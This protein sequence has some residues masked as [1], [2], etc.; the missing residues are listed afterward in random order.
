M[1][2]KNLIPLLFALAYVVVPTSAVYLQVTLTDGA[3]VHAMDTP[4]T[5]VVPAVL[6]A[7]PKDP[8]PLIA[9]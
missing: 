1:T 9:L 2:K 4:A 7:P 8:E 6:R 5:P 3:A